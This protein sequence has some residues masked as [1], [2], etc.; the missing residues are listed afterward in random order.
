DRRLGGGM[1]PTII[2]EVNLEFRGE[3]GV[4]LGQLCDWLGAPAPV[5]IRKAIRELYATEERRHSGRCEHGVHAGEWCEPCN[6]AYKRARIEN[7]DYDELRDG[8]LRNQ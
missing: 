4:E 7:G 2:R 6:A 8:T 3:D 1:R 5:V